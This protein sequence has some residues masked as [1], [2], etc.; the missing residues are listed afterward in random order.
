MHKL[1]QRYSVFTLMPT[2]EEEEG[3]VC[4]KKKKEMYVTYF[5]KIRGE[6]PDLFN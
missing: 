1:Q 6:L 2:K 3:D 5:G 4:K